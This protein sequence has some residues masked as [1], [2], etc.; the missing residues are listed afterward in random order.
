[1]M[2]TL[3]RLIA[4]VAR[5]IVR[6]IVAASA[7]LPWLLVAAIAG[8][9]TPAT[10]LEF[11]PQALE[12]IR[13]LQEEKAQL[14]PHEQKIDSRLRRLIDS[15]RATPKFPG[16]TDIAHPQANPDGTVLLD[17]DTFAGSDVKALI[18]AVEAAGGQVLNAS[19]RYRT[20]RV[21][22]QVAD[23]ATIA[24]L[25][26][27]RIV[28]P[29]HRAMTNKVN[30]SQG[31]VTHRAAAAR[32]FFGFDGTGV[33]VCVLS[34]GVDSLAAVQATGDLPPVVQVLPGQ[35]GSGDEGTAMLEIVHDLAPGATLAF[36]TAFNGS[37][38][39]AQNIIDLKNV[40][41]NIIVDDV[42]YFAES[43]FQDNN[44]ADA[45]NQVS[46]AGVLY[47]SSAGNSGNLDDGTAG[48]WEGNFTPNGAIPGLPAGTVAHNFGG[49]GQ[50]NAF[51][52]GSGNPISLHWTDKFGASGNDYDLYVLNSALTVVRDS[53]TNV[54]SGFGDPFEIVG[55]VSYAA[56][57][58]VVVLQH[59]GASIRMI[60][61]ATNRGRLTFNTPGV[62]K[63]HNGGAN[64]VSVAATPAAGAFGGPPNPTGPYPSPFSAT[65]LSELFSSDG[66]RRMF[67]DFSGNLLPG[68]PAG[69]FTASGGIVLQK[70]D[71]TAADGVMTAAP[72]FNPFYG[73]SA[74]AP[75]AAAIAAL[76]KHAFPAKT[77]AQIKSAM[78][79]SAI[80]IEAA[81]WDRDTGVGIVMAYET[82]QAQGATPAAVISVG[83]VTPTQVAGNGD[84]FVDPGED[85]KFDITLNNTGAAAAYGIVATLVSDTP[86]VV[87]TS[88][89]V[90]YPNIGAGGSAPNPGS[91]PFRFSVTTAACGTPTSFT[92][93]VTFGGG[94]GAP[95]TAT[96]PLAI[97]GLGGTSTFTYAGG[98]VP[99]PDGAGVEVPGAT[100]TANLVVA[101]LP[102]TVGKVT[103]KFLG[104]ACST[105]IGATTVG[106][107]HSWV[108]DLVI[109]L[110]APD[111][112]TTTTLVNRMGGALNSGNNFCQTTLDDAS[113]GAVIDTLGAASNP[114]T[115]SFKPSGPLS[116]FVGTNGNGTW[117]LQAND[118]EPTDTGSIRAWSLDI[119]PVACTAASNPT[120]ISATKTVA[121]SFVPGGTVDYKVT[122][123]NTGTG[124]QVD[125]PGD[126]FTDTLPPQLTFVSA[127][128][129][130]GSISLAGSTVKWNGSIP[131]G[132]G[133]VT[134]QIT[135]KVNSGTTGLTVTNQGTVNF[136]PN[137][138]GT[139]SS[140]VL[141]DDPAVGGAA[142]PTQFVVAAASGL[143]RTFVA[144]TGNDSNPCTLT[145]PCRGFQAALALTVPDGEIAVLDAAGYGFVSIDKPVTIIA[146]PGVYAGISVT[147]G[148]GID[149]NPG[150][151]RVVLRGLTLTGLGGDFGVNMMSGDALYIEN[152]VIGGFSN[153]GVYAVPPM[154]ST[155]FVRNSTIR[156]NGTGALF[157]T[158]SGASGVLRAI[159]E[160]SRFENNGTGI[161]FTNGSALGTISDTTV[162]GGAFGLNVNPT[163]AGAATKVTVRKSTFTKA[164][165][166]GVRVGG[167]AGTT[168][169][170]GL[171]QS[172]VTESGIG[173]EMLTGGTA[174][175][176][177]TAIVRNT[178]GVTTVSGTAVSLGDNQL[179]RNGTNGTFSATVPK[180]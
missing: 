71:I 110:V 89:P 5:R 164:S 157:G 125:N 106:L 51:T 139:N 129:S 73:T 86:G 144:S 34:D 56:G 123:T 14:A 87:V 132:G 63:G 50:S 179:T 104:S 135:A 160:H 116:T 174:H 19:V 43:P 127:S 75:H 29:E 119:R 100:A 138:S 173:V 90:S 120:A 169:A 1:M 25:P 35:A 137:H 32:S 103:F 77:A 40:G 18:D 10:P 15:R 102:G 151:G 67:F 62:V 128:A 149:V 170:A 22:L 114:F 12:Q 84:A 59:S 99:I 16:L 177:G 155:V 108:G 80:D 76:V 107:D 17:I 23:I 152:C 2:Q 156:D 117:K 33:K 88:G 83:T 122:L 57:D 6:P 163:T 61:V 131:G 171:V 154:G 26:G 31:D 91:T 141:T 74:A 24:M 36:A 44:I 27:V 180:Q 153:T 8:A 3:T 65:N 158:S 72:G 48:T 66:P 109:K 46:A 172:Q 145:S 49:G 68:A 82:L 78:M 105:A 41:C 13:L 58:R 81:G 146:P 136:D 159:V 134:I 175:V 140:S 60:N 142:N 147:S 167:A 113:A 143:P 150:A 70:P 96:I 126:E 176:S 20:A 85:W 165:T 93:T 21:R 53:S 121:G 111:G 161:G 30:T 39:F 38:S 148:H 45:V 115:G 178:T 133:S 47:F 92:L 42:T 94:T 55:S 79:A 9:Q 11:G 4:R 130:S 95:A 98:V 54:Q 52:A 37:A 101:G 112:T 28:Y 69:D 168:A 64:T 7:L 124:T 118:W 166:T 97:G 162:I